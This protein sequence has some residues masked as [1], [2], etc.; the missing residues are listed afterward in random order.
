[1]GLLD[2]ANAKAAKMM[3]RSEQYEKAQEQ[4]AEGMTFSDRLAADCQEKGGDRAREGEVWVLAGTNEAVT[5][6]HNASW[7]DKGVLAAQRV[8]VKVR[9]VS[10]GKKAEV[11][12]NQ[13]RRPEDA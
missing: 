11:L 9:F 12:A 2:K 6:R 5:I 3:G 7:T 13:L 8:K 4:K 1:M 10:S